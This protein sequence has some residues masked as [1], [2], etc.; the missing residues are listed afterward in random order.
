MTGRPLPTLRARCRYRMGM[1]PPQKKKQTA[2]W[3]G[4]QS[5]SCL[6]RLLGKRAV[7]AY[8]V[9]ELKTKETG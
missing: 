8:R 9:E 5:H 7:V 2:S 6:F 1:S 3:K 4:Q